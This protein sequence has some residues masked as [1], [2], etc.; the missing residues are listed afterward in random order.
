MPPVRSTNLNLRP[1]AIC[2]AISALNSAVL[3]L[4][5]CSTDSCLGYTTPPFSA[6]SGTFFLIVCRAAIWRNAHCT[7]T[8]A[9]AF[10]SA[11]ARTSSPSCS[12]IYLAVNSSKNI[13]KPRLIKSIRDIKISEFRVMAKSAHPQIMPHPLLCKLRL[14]RRTLDE[15]APKPLR[16]PTLSSSHPL[17]TPNANQG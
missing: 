6:H 15:A 1:H 7:S 10:L 3:W 11:S 12:S 16:S 13:F 9:G 17:P 5:H 4:E 14:K 8:P 2:P